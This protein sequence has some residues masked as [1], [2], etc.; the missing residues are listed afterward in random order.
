MN[1]SNNFS[2]LGKYLDQPALVKKLHNAL[3]YTLTAGA[4]GYGIYDT[5][6]T[7]EKERKNKF[8]KNFSV[9]SFTVASALISTRGLKIKGKQI[10]EGLIELPHLHKHD[11]EDALNI[12]KDNN[13]ATNLINKVKGGEVLKLSEVKSLNNELEKI[14]P[15]KNLINKIIPEPHNHNP[16]EELGK[17]SLLGLI[18]VTGG[19]A[20]GITGDKLTQ[21][22]WKKNLPDKLK[23]GSYQYLANIFLCNV[24]AGS[25]L[26][27][28]NK[29]NVKSRAAKLAGILSGVVLVGLAAGSTIANYIGKKCIN[30]LLDNKINK[31]AKPEKVNNDRHPELL[32]LGLHLDDMASAGFISGLKFIGPLLPI[33]Y[34]ISA[35]RAGIGYRN[36]NE[37]KNKKIN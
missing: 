19:I 15:E 3:P 27:L 4:A 13:S 20:G 14:A 30:P 37:N 21:K 22:D 28:M 2:L 34:S 32:D 9:L 35:Y 10:F 5:Y 7:P 31:P 8:I 1:A 23:E 18:P 6:K 11:I 25:A 17:L 16:F 26:I 33:M 12:A 36:G 29:M 24:G